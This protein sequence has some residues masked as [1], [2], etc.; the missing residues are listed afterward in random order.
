MNM[1]SKIV[2]V[3][4][5]A[6]LIIIYPLSVSSRENSFTNNI[7]IFDGKK[8]KSCYVGS[9]VLE[10]TTNSL[11]GTIMLLKFSAKEVALSPEYA[12]ELLNDDYSVVLETLYSHKLKKGL[13]M[14]V[15]TKTHMTSL[16]YSQGDT[17]NKFVHV[18]DKDGSIEI[19]NALLDKEELN[20]EFI[21]K[22]YTSRYGV[23]KTKNFKEQYDLYKQCVRKL[24]KDL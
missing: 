14:S 4:I 22:D 19:I 20:I 13:E 10:N 3:L 21:L 17:E 5:A 12:K 24:D 6:C 18:A 16:K 9:D 1:Y 15:L 11:L 2:L 8:N 23:V 7:W